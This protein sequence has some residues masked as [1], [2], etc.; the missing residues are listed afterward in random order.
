MAKTTGRVG[1]NV[2]KIGQNYRVSIFKVLS[3]F[4]EVS[5]KYP[6]N[7]EKTNFAVVER[8]NSKK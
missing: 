8:K 4:P 2:K 5:L 3:I 1:K 6:A 7:S